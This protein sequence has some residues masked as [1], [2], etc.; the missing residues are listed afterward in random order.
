M[1]ETAVY[2]EFYGCDGAAMKL[3]IGLGDKHD[4]AWAQEMSA[5]R[6]YLKRKADPRS[7]PM[8][9]VVRH[10]SERVGLCIVGIP[11]ATK[12]RRWWGYPELPTQWQVVD[13][14]R[15]WLDPVIQRG[16]D[17]ALPGIVPGFVD[18]KGVFRPTV[19]TWLIGEV[20]RQ[21]QRDRVAMW[22]PVYLDEP[23][24]ILLAISYHD[25]ALHR[26]TIYKESGA[27]PMYANEDGQATPGS[28][29]KVGWCWRLPEPDWTWRELTWLRPRTIRMTI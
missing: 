9:Y 7:R 22:P 2:T 3:V 1:V 17:W 21:V 8:A 15:I 11:H 14:C 24:H 12:N 4:L 5:A 13:L 18:R 19:A 28:S 26:G 20:L 29:G 16:G 6:H 23:Y 27:V 10:G 25:P